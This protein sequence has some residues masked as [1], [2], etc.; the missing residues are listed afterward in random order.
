MDVT[1]LYRV[2]SLKKGKLKPAEFRLREGEKGLS[3]FAR[4]ERPGLAAVIEA[5]RSAGKQ[6]ELGAAVITARDLQ[7]LGL[8]LTPTPGGTPDAE[9]NALHHEAGFSWL[10]RLLLRLRG[11]RVHDYFNEHFSLRVFALARLLD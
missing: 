5:V 11:V 1:D 2:V 6:G 7:V 9:V 4:V 8:V 10:R 3:L